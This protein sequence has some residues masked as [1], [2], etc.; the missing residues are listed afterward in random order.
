MTRLYSIYQLRI[1]FVLLLFILCTTTILGKMFYIQSFQA[2]SR[3]E[4]TIRAGFAE[5]S[6]KGFRGNIYDRNGQTLA[7]TI[8]TYTFSVNT[9]KEVAKAKIVNLFC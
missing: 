1:R 6:V 2:A 4:E 9:H 7:E 3:R 5:R 8:K